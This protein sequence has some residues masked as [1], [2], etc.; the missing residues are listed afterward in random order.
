MIIQHEATKARR[1][2]EGARPSSIRI[3]F[4]AVMA[5][6][7]LPLGLFA[8]EGDK[9]I[10]KTVGDLKVELMVGLDAATV[11]T[12]PVTIR[13]HDAQDK[14]VTDATVGLR[15]AMDQGSAMSMDM[16][17]EKTKT[18][19]LSADGSTAGTLK[20]RVDL[21]FKG[22]WIASMDLSRGGTMEKAT[23]NFEVADAGPNWTILIVFGLIVVVVI[24]GAALLRSRKPEA[25]MAV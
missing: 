4:L 19:D 21:G 24:G 5:L 12:N 1:S 13:I 23:F 16:D 3:L 18:V 7:M 15:I 17:K 8:N 20:G 11:G 14:P 2:G 6:T 9:G 10:V 25:G 22:K